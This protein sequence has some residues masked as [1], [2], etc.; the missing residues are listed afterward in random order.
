MSLHPYNNFSSAQR[1]RAQRWLREQWSSGVLHRP[2]RCHACGQDRGIFDAHAED[3][4][5][6]FAAG[7]TDAHHL[8]FTCHMIVHYRF[9]KRAAWD[10]YRAAIAGGGHFAPVYRRSF[11]GFAAAHLD[12]EAGYAAA[13]A[14]F[15]V[16]PPPAR[17]V[18][19]EIDAADKAKMAT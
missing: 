7:K 14:K 12:G 15:V 11:G 17:R 19:D 6:P 18:L 1:E 9:K 2:C 3:Y 4:S 13:L 5:E 8:C 10:R 16:G